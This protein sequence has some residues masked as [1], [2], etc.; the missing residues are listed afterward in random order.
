[1]S[2]EEDDIG[3]DDILINKKPE[4]IVNFNNDN[5]STEYAHNARIFKLFMTIL[6]ILTATT[7]VIIDLNIYKTIFTFCFIYT[8]GHVTAIFVIITSAK[9]LHFI[10]LDMIGIYG[11]KLFSV[12]SNVTQDYY[13]C[14]KSISDISAL[15]GSSIH[16]FMLIGNSMQYSLFLI[17][18][19]QKITDWKHSHDVTILQWISIYLLF[20]TDIGMFILGVWWIEEKSKLAMIMHYIGAFSVLVL[21]AVAFVFNQNFSAFSIVLVTIQVIIS[22][23]WVV[24]YIK[25]PNKHDDQRV[26]DKISY[27]CILTEL[28]AGA[29]SM[30]ISLI[31]LWCMDG[32]KVMF[33]K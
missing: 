32:D 16:T 8:I 19:I 10:Q 31:F 21:C 4:S 13:K 7:M 24:L 25:L 29:L 12:P 11:Y 1:M 20:V 6:V 14:I 18:I 2:A 3:V 5:L 28:I 9:H 23:L 30:V 27:Y 26:V 15:S 33:Q 22:G 17:A